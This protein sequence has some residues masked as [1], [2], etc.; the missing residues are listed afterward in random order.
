MDFANV[1]DMYGLFADRLD[2]VD[3]A[4]PAAPLHIK[5]GKGEI[6]RSDHSDVQISIMDMP[7]WQLHEDVE[8][9]QLQ[10]LCLA[11]PEPALGQLAS[12]CD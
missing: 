8:S 5:H 12:L 9:S 6:A 7:A 3:N 4:A 10:P 11:C 2:A 1:E